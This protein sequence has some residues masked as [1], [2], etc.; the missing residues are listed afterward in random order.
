MISLTDGQ[1]LGNCCIGEPVGRV[2][3]C[4]DNNGDVVTLLVTSRQRRQWRMM[5]EQRSS[6]FLWDGG[7]LMTSV[8]F[9]MA[10]LANG[11]VEE[12]ASR[13]RLQGLKQLSVEKLASLKQKLAETRSKTGRKRVE[14][15]R[16]STG[17]SE[18]SEVNEKVT[19]LEAT[20]LEKQFARNR[21]LLSGYYQPGSLLTVYS[22]EVDSVPM[23]VYKLPGEVQEVVLCDRFVYIVD[24]SRRI[25]RV[26]SL[27]CAETRLEDEGEF[28]WDSVVAE[29]AFE[30]RI[31]GIYKKT[32]ATMD[33]EDRRQKPFVL[34]R[35]EHELNIRRPR[36]DSCIVVT[37]TEVREVGTGSGVIE[38]LVELLS[39]GRFFRDVELLTQ[40]FGLS[41]QQLLEYSGDIALSQERFAQAISFYRLSKCRVLKSVLKFAVAGH[42]Q[43]LLGYITACL[44]SSN[45]D[46]SV[47]TKK[48]LSNLAIMSYTEILLRTSSNVFQRVSNFKKFISFLAYNDYYDEILAVNVICQTGLWSILTVIGRVRCLAFD[49]VEILCKVMRNPPQPQASLTSDIT[50][51]C[52]H[53][54]I[55][56]P[57]FLPCVISKP[58]Y[59]CLFLQYVKDNLNQFSTPVL[60]RLANSLDPSHPIAWSVISKTLQKHRSNQSSSLDSTLDS[61]DSDPPDELLH[62]ARD[63]IETFIQTLIVLNRKTNQD[64]DITLLPLVEPP[65]T[66]PPP[67]AHLHPKP[68]FLSSGSSHVALVRNNTLY[69]WGASQNGCLGFGPMVTKYSLPQPVE[70]LSNFQLELIN[71]SAGRGHTVILTNYG[72]WTWGSNVYGQLGLGAVVY[73]APYPVLVEGLS[74]ENVV[75]VSAGQYHTL[76]LTSDGKV[77]SWG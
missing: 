4:Q 49:I 56:D 17:S 27:Q 52:F 47:S 65:Q 61:L 41:A 54:C 9:V 71:V 34:A 68:R 66:A 40:V 73:Q 1:N 42:C 46:M 35:S 36:I 19:Y 60:K 22:V 25:L 12:K 5:L 11:H 76:A 7:R 70:V 77:Y 10:G 30:G 69:T 43:E 72:V 37:E 51:D 13:S 29:C 59:S 2:D 24:A 39:T 74:E 38:K 20:V 63:L 67:P 31:L 3:V 15:D 14:D 58:Q 21:H 62:S 6:G 33:V 64:F 26:L 23:F 28:N 18:S 53:S 57:M 50:H 45:A 75:D 32:D 44:A 55:S 48:H 16:E 8:E